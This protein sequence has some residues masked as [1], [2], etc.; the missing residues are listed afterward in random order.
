MP[1]LNC[2]QPTG[3]AQRGLCGYCYG[4]LARTGQLP[5]PHGTTPEEVLSERD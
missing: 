1:C 3:L 5:P 2:D 4:V